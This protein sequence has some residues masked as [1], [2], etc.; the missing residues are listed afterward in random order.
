VVDE[1][2]WLWM[3]IEWNPFMMML[4]SMTT[5]VINN[6]MS[7]TVFGKSHGIEINWIWDYKVC[8]NGWS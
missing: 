2:H 5:Y 1:L 6:G 4:A 3:K 8:D 7:K